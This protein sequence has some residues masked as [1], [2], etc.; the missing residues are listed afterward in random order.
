VASTVTLAATASDDVA[1]VGVQFKVNGANVGAEVL[2]PPYF[3]PWNTTAVADGSHVVTAVARDP[4]GNSVTSAPVSVTVSNA[5][6]TAPSRIGQ[7]SSN[8]SWPL[9][10]IHVALLPS[11]QVLAWDGAAQNGAAYVWNPGT[12]GF[13]S[14]TP[15]D[16]IFCAGFSPLPDGR[17]LVVG[18]HIANY[19][20]LRDTNIFDGATQTWAGVAPMS[21]GRWYPTATTLPD[22]RVLVISGAID[23]EQCIA[24]I[25]EIYSPATNSWTSLPTAA[26]EIP[27]Y[28]HLFVLPD[29]RVLVTS[30]FESAMPTTVLDVASGAWTAVDP[31]ILD[32]H[33]AAMY[34]GGKI[35]KSG[36]SG[37]SDPPFAIAQP[38]TFVLDMNQPSPAWRQTA[39]MAFAR[40]FHNLTLLPDGSVLANGGTRYTDPFDE[41]QA[42]LTSE[43]WSPATETWTT[44][45]SMST[46]RVYHSIALLLPDG[47]VLVAGGGRFGNPTGDFHDKLNAQI[48]SPPYLFK[49]ARPT[50]TSAPSAVSYGS[51]FTVT[52]P[53]AA[54]IASVVLMRTGSVTHGFNQ[55]QSYVPL[56]FTLG[57]GTLT[58]EAPAAAAQAVPGH[59]L[60]FIVDANGVPSVAPIVRV[61]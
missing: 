18:G 45:A 33:S 29:G 1:V 22:G 58:V 30:S 14:V 46:V 57:S 5:T 2:N 27:I 7:W 11:G 35:V 51:S 36:T 52:T 10:A 32:G 59:Y 3:V 34:R 47:R 12:N 55:S 16:N 28:P 61:H 42:T 48:Y 49:G 8:A 21:F 9:V 56:S 26:L 44:M 23:C 41:S 17:T 24:E 50:I 39:P 6:A 60:L 53:N 4:A 54:S 15:P 20:G 19:V 37:N 43:L 31:G 25:P 40:S 13:S 38:T